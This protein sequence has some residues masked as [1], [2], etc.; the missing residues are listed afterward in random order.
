MTQSANSKEQKCKISIYR[1]IF[2]GSS[3]SASQVCSI[4]VLLT[5]PS[6]VPGVCASGVCFC[7]LTLIPLQSGHFHMVKRLL[8]AQSLLVE[9]SKVNIS[10]VTDLY[11]FSTSPIRKISQTQKILQVIRF[12]VFYGLHTFLCSAQLPKE[13]TLFLQPEKDMKLKIRDISS[14]AVRKMRGAGSLLC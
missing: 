3:K 2:Y 14:T 12:C 5:T 4:K 9:Y 13:H 1:Q 11:K 6:H 10:Y 8:N 7:L